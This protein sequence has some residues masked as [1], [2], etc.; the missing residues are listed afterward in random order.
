MGTKIADLDGI[1]KTIA[2]TPSGSSPGGALAV[3]YSGGLDSRFLIHMALRNKISIL[4]LHIRGP[5]IPFREHAEAV[6]WA[7]AVAVPL[8]VIDSDPLTMPTLANNPKDRCYH[9]KKALFTTVR[10]AAKGLALCDG[11]NASDM[12]EYR[13]GLRAIAELGIHSPLAKAGMTKQDIHTIAAMTGM[14][15]PDQAARPCLLT[16]FA[17]GEAISR[18]KLL[19]VDAAEEV[20]QAVFAKHGLPEAPFRIRFE[21]AHTPALHTSLQTIAPELKRDL[22]A[23]LAQAGLSSAYIHQMQTLSGYFDKQ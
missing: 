11:T 18:G 3:A 20:A 5:H 8:T 12:G 1:L 2:A 10:N 4:A 23:A 6:A 9:C 17:Y 16:R 19:A 15:N 22:V 7:K 21:N 14:D 13:P